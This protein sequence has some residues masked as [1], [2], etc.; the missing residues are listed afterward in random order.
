[1]PLMSQ[2]GG[3]RVSGTET[4]EIEA[5]AAHC[6]LYHLSYRPHEGGRAGLEPATSPLVMEVAAACAPAVPDETCVLPRSC[7]RGD[8]RRRYSTP[9]FAQWRA[10]I[11]T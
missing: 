2:Q 7:L 3:P 4:A 5:A 8:G 11:R 10:R 9:L 1:M 6:V